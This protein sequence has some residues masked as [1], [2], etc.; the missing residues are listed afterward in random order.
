MRK[1]QHTVDKMS[2]QTTVPHDAE[3]RSA[4]LTNIRVAAARAAREAA[5]RG[6]L[7]RQEPSILEQ[8]QQCAAKAV[9]FQKRQ[10]REDAGMSD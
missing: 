6:D 10:E 7:R 4:A 8:I 1:V 9:E 2:G 5:L 3:V